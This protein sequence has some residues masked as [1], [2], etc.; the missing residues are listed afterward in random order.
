MY[1]GAMLL[2]AGVVFL[3]ILGS[4]E[5]GRLIPGTPFNVCVI[6]GLSLL[7]LPWIYSNTASNYKRWGILITLLLISL[8]PVLLHILLY[9]LVLIFLN[10]IL[11]TESILWN[12][13]WIV[14]IDVPLMLVSSYLL[15]SV[16]RQNVE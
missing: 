1:I 2:V 15:H 16:S 10:A 5:N 6:G 11:H 13:N 12:T 3:S 14:L 4:Q 7:I 8:I 9:L